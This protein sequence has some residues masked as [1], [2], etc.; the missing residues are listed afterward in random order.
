MRVHSHWVF[1]ENSHSSQP[2]SQ[3]VSAASVF[4][5]KPKRKPGTETKAH[6][7]IPSWLIGIYA[8]EVKSLQP[9]RCVMDSFPAVSR[10]VC[11]SVWLLNC[12][13]M[14]VSERRSMYVRVCMYACMHICMYVWMGCVRSLAMTR[15]LSACHTRPREAAC[16]RAYEQGCGAVWKKGLTEAG[17]S[18]V[19]FCRLLETFRSSLRQL[20]L[21]C[22]FVCLSK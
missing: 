9:I 11:L 13:C 16:R 15:S 8:S 19:Y 3:S 21:F 6:Y 18:E 20:F 22:L 12:S 2:A 4:P 14:C 5:L 17:H 10:S 1:P 7:K